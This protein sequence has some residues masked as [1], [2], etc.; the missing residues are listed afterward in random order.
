MAV[1]FIFFIFAV[2]VIL[3]GIGF[4]L[5]NYPLAAL[6]S[7]GLIIIGIYMSI[8]GV[9]SVDNILTQGLAIISIGVGAFVFIAGSVEQI[10]NI[11]EGT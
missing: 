8:N 4:F 6:A 2:I 3:L 10:Q 1:A 11:T 7:M 5:E 9:E